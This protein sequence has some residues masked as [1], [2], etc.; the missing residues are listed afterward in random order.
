MI[1]LKSVDIEKKKITTLAVPVCEDRE[2]HDGILKTLCGSA[3]KF[4]EFDGKTGEEIILHN[5]PGVN[6]TR[7]IFVGLGKLDKI[8]PEALR[9]FAGKTVK[10]C[11]QKKLTEVSL[12]TPSANDLKMEMGGL[13][14][15]LLEGAYLGNHRFD[16]YKKEK[17]LKALNSINVITNPGAV[18]KFTR[19]VPHV[20]AVCSGT[21]LARE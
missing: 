5:P 7:V 6:I 3:K 20:T 19:L 9:V 12:A 14:E 16:K 10:A 1:N 18:K 4:K 2:I 13:I 8:D 15:A 11:I 17:K 21:L